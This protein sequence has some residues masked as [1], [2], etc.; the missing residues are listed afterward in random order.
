MF[1]TPMNVTYVPELDVTEELDEKGVA[2]FQ[3]LIGILRWAIE[4]KSQDLVVQSI[5]IKIS[6]QS[7]ARSFD[8]CRYTNYLL[9]GGQ[10]N[11]DKRDKE[12]NKVTKNIVRLLL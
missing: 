7:K 11:K 6:G 2:I 10:G 9:Q 12:S 3:E 5:N 8:L 1:D 4:K